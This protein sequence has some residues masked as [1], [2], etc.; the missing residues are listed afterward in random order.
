M[1]RLML[2][3]GIILP[4]DVVSD[5]IQFFYGNSSNSITI[6]AAELIYDNQFIVGF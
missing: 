6:K 4:M 2:Q 3:V 5:F 1:H